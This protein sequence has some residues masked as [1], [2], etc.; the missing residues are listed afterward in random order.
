MLN[1]SSSPR[2]RFWCASLRKGS[3][4]L[5]SVQIGGHPAPTIVGD[6]IFADAIFADVLLQLLVGI[7]LADDCA[8]LELL[9]LRRTTAG[10][11]LLEDAAAFHV[12]RRAGN[13][14]LASA[15]ISTGLLSF[16]LFGEAKGLALSV[17][18]HSVVGQLPGPGVCMEDDTGLG[19]RSKYAI[20]ICAPDEASAGISAVQSVRRG[21]DADAHLYAICVPA[22]LRCA[23]AYPA[24]PGGSVA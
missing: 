3:D 12:D 19:R 24:Q 22:D 4:V 17:C 13:N 2:M 15:R 20:A 8:F 21:A 11:R 10:G 1:W 5:A 14:L 16:L 18:D 6:S 7:P 9:Q 23:R